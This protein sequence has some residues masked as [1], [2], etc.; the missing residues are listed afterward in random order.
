MCSGLI[1]QFLRYSTVSDGKLDD[2]RGDFCFGLLSEAVEDERLRLV[3]GDSG[4]EVTLES[5]D[6]LGLL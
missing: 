4:D 2:L 3:L 6:M 1:I 5:D